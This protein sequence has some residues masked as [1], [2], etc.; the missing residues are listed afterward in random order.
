[1]LSLI[2]QTSQDK[3]KGRAPSNLVGEIEDLFVPNSEDSLEYEELAGPSGES[4]DDYS[5]SQDSGPDSEDEEERD[6]T[7]RN[8]HKSSKKRTPRVPIGRSNDVE[9]DEKLMVRA[10]LKASLRDVVNRGASTSAGSTGR[11]VPRRT[12]RAA[13]AAEHRILMERA[14][15]VDFEVA[16]DSDPEGEVM[17]ITDSEDKPIA[18]RNKPILGKGRGRDKGLEETECDTDDIH[19]DHLSARKE[20]RRLSRLEKQEIRMLEIKLGRRLTHVCLAGNLFTPIHPFLVLTL[21]SRR[22][23]DLRFNCTDTTPSFVKPGETSKR[24]SELWNPRKRSSHQ[25]S[26]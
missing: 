13:A 7:L 24:I 19:R 6:I 15:A 1:M 8:G 10:A 16:S 23:R 11:N 21:F 12:R 18:Q 26:E 2:S 5:D 14:S 17:E 22:P 4:D 3:G 25:G 9:G 20:A